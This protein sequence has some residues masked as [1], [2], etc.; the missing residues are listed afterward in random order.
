MVVYFE[1]HDL[2]VNGQVAEQMACTTPQ[3]QTVPNPI[4]PFLPSFLS[5]ASPICSYSPSSLF[6]SVSA[7]PTE[8][9]RRR[10]FRWPFAAPP[11]HW[12]EG[13]KMPDEKRNLSPPPLIP[14]SLSELRRARERG[15]KG[16]GG[17][18]VHRLCSLRIHCIRLRDT[19]DLHA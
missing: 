18:T 8:L 11:A 7:Q 3:V 17:N 15:M 1:F 16:G 19:A 13:R 4:F 10:V 2:C 5:I 12:R 14:F 6:Q 9:G